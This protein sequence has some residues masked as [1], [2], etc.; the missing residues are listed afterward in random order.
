M[1]ISIKNFPELK[2][3]IQKITNNEFYVGV[4]E[5]DKDEIQALNTLG[6][7]NNRGCDQCHDKLETS[8]ILGAY[9]KHQMILVTYSEFSS[10]NWA[11]GHCF[12]YV[13]DKIYIFSNFVDLGEECM[14]D[15]LRESINHSK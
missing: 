10:E 12:L 8:I 5:A 4:K 11:G 6:L 2:N 1:Y 7:I 14:D 9:G 15:L 13:P 3:D